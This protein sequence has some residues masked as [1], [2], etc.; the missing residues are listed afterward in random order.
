MRTS[1]SK[2]MPSDFDN[3]ENKHYEFF[4]SLISFCKTYNCF[5]KYCKI[6]ENKFEKINKYN[7]FNLTDEKIIKLRSDS[8]LDTDSEDEEDI[9]LN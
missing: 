8:E 2:Y 6:L 5:D 3:S 9:N 7:L 4:S 1:F